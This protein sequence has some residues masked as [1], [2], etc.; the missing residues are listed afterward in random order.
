MEK[1]RFIPTTK[2]FIHAPQKKPQWPCEKIK[3]GGKRYIDAISIGTN[4]RAKPSSLSQ[5]N[6]LIER[7]GFNAE[8]GASVYSAS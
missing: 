6:C 8:A 1:R 7:S 3:I 2:P 5:K 4:G